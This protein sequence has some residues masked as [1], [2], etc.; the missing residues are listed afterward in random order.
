LSGHLW[1]GRFYSC[2]LDDSHLFTAGRYVERNPVRAGIVKEAWDW[3]G[4]R[5]SV[6]AVSERKALAQ[7][8]NG[9]CPYLK[10]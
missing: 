5:K 7:K 9:G 1:Q 8:I 4:D 6:A 3:Q 2:I 10:R